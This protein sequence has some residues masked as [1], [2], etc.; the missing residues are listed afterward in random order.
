VANVPDVTVNSFQ[1][2]VLEAEKPVL[3]DFWASWCAPCRAM[4][5][6][7]EE[8]AGDYSERLKVCKIDTDQNPDL[9]SRYGVMSIPTLILFREGEPVH[10]FTGFLPKRD[11]AAKLDAAL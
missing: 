4:K 6:V 7:V 5:P 8:V 11:L 10:R 1:A 2:E 3:V 9:A